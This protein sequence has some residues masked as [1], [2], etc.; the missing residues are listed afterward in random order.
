MTYLASRSFCRSSMMP[1]EGTE[2]PL[3]PVEAEVWVMTAFHPLRSLA[4]QNLVYQFTKL[5]EAGQDYA[6]R[7]FGPSGRPA[8]FEAELCGFLEAQGGVGHG[9]DFAG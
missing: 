7:S 6:F 5:A 9:T 2:K 1:R 3:K 8:A 4:L